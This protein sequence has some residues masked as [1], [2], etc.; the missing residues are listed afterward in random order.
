MARPTHAR[1][2]RPT[3]RLLLTALITTGL[4]AGC[5]P[6][7]RGTLTSEGDPARQ[8]KT[9][10]T[11]L[12]QADAGKPDHELRTRRHLD[13]IG[14]GLKR[15]GM[16]KVTVA[17][18]GDKAPPKSDLVVKAQLS[19]ERTERTVQV[20]QYV[21]TPTWRQVC[22]NTNGGVRCE[23]RTMYVDQFAGYAPQLEVHHDYR[24]DLYWR[25]RRDDVLLLHHR[26]DSHDPPCAEDVNFATL[27]DY[28]M[29]RISLIEPKGQQSF[30]VELTRDQCKG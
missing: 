23:M 14:E 30:K 22:W 8:V 17:A 10:Q 24:V 28:G 21:S 9:S 1:P 6:M 15:L 20:P 19:L 18:P 12:L 26:I 27:I 3:M 25:D 11:V 5:A 7:V 13:L 4:L 16:Q 29:E 2:T